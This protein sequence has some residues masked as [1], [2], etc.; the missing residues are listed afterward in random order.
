MFLDSITL[1]SAVELATPLAKKLFSEKV[2]PII[3]NKVGSY[4]KSKKAEKS[5]ND[6]S[7]KYLAR[8]VGQCSTLNTIAFQNSPKKLV[9]LYMPLTI[10]SDLKKEK[11]TVDS[12]VDIFQ[13]HTHILI[14]DNAGMGKS[15]LSKRVVLNIAEQGEF[16][17]VYIELRQI[18]A[19]PIDEQIKAV[20]G[21]TEESEA[22][23]IKDLPLIYIFDGLDEVATDKKKQVVSYLKDFIDFVG[24]AKVL[25]T[26]RQESYLAEFYSFARYTIAPLSKKE[27]CN[28][29][30]KYDPAGSLASA[31]IRGI[32]NDRSGMIREFLSTPLYVS[33]LFCSYRHK[34]IIP[35]RKD[36]F[37]SQ[38]YDALFES[39]DL[40]KEI[41]FV[42][43][44]NSKL[45]STEFHSVLR[46][47]GF[48]CLKN[49]GELEFQKDE[50]EIIVTD[51]MKDIVGM[52]SSP[53]EFVK[54]LTTTVPLFVREGATVRWSH[55][56]LM[57][58]FAAMFI[59]NDIKEKQKDVLLKIFSSENAVS[60]KN[61]LS[62]CC[63]I[64]FSSFRATIVKKV[65]QEF[66]DYHSTA[67]SSF[68]NK[69]IRKE[70]IER[71]IAL[72]FGRTIAFEL[73]DKIDGSIAFESKTK[74]V[75]KLLSIETSRFSGASEIVWVSANCSI[76][77]VEYST[78]TAGIVSMIV[79][80]LPHLF[81]ADV[82][83]NPIA[84]LSGGKLKK[85]HFYVIDDSSKSPVNTMRNFDL[86]TN[87]IN[88]A[89]L[90]LVSVR[91]ELD[92]INADASNGVNR[93]LSDL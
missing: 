15:T 61:M 83:A 1:D 42:R 60:Y 5:F 80:K 14:N 67:Y 47:L 21:I 26:S 72:S 92:L 77:S 86:A 59:C 29:L 7:I 41:G 52:K 71:R 84:A 76:Y 16:I 85:N 54:D 24:T 74:Q 88:G 65:L 57:E 27:A 30:R 37:Y 81:I 49:N 82:K 64:D 33:L 32:D 3:Q 11:I 87:L 55:K 18:L 70:L 63:D 75:E 46:R 19:I 51:L 48:W 58:Y 23:L 79:K 40:S 9:D 50:L 28:L 4:F 22:E 20:L 34:T 25:I 39:H 53:S 36:L 62:L 31:L 66:V 43:P 2:L 90:S 12:G 91:K 38:V 35:Q 6:N 44:K 8:V 56:S 73:I 68:S 45:D 13:Y 10:S 93:L 69:R 78:L 17:P 89:G